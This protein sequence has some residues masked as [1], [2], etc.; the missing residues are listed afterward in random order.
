MIEQLPPHESATAPPANEGTDPPPIRKVTRQVAFEG[1][2]DRDRA[3]KIAALFD[4]MAHDWAAR[5]VD[6]GRSAP[7]VDALD[8]GGLDRRGRWI[9][10]GS[11]TGAGT[12]ILAP[13]VPD[14][15]A[16][17][18]AGAMLAEAPA[19]LAPRVQGDA[20][21][22]PFAD[23]TFDV[24]VMV[25]MLLF[26]EEVDRVLRPTGAVVW[27]NTLGDQT[28]IHLPVDDVRQA[29]PGDW[30]GVTADAGTGFWAVFTRVQ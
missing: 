11:G 3:H 10:L 16:F 22:M 5:S 24:V 30:R 23:D 4:G 28:P 1:R 27:I 26:P 12:A 9:E 19:H 6:P 13:H 2:W 18:L 14:L 7:V 20:S 17:D 29:L 8:R 25:N 15:V 21:V